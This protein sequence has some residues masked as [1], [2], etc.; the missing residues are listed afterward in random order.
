MDAHGGEIRLRF[1]VRN[2]GTRAGVAEPQLYVRDLL[3]SVV[4]PVKELKAF[5]RAELPAGES[6]RVI[7]TV[8]TDMLCFTGIEGRRIVEPGEFEF[9]VGTSSADIRLRATVNVTGKVRTLGR[10]WRMESRCEVER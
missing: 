4:R 5:G 10:E 7:F 1:T 8:P 2:T 9:Q 3:A 6:A